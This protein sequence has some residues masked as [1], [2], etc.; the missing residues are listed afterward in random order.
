MHDH[1]AGSAG[2]LAL[3]PAAIA[4]L[5]GA[6]YVGAAWRD[7]HRRAWPMHRTA[8]WILGLAAATAAVTGPLADRAHEDLVAHMVGHLLLGMLAPLL[9][10][11]AAPVTLALRALDV[12]PA[13]RL[14]ALLRSRPL[15]AV[16]HP[17]PAAALDAG[18][19]WVV[20]GTPVLTRMHGDPLLTALVDVHVLL[21]GCLFTAAVV[22]V[23]P[24]PHRPSARY[25][26]VVLVAAM[27]AHGILAKQLYAMPPAGVPRAEAELAAQVMYHAV[28][29][30][31]LVLLGVG[32]YRA[33][34]P[35]GA[36]MPAGSGRPRIAPD[37]Q[38][39]VAEAAG[40]P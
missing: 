37:G 33:S 31:L 3:A 21:A 39:P 2:L 36:G 22:G 19:M 11:R 8:L 14:T 38:G 9:L 24:S 29:A 25:R 6:A 10:V 26:G 12:V 15:R 17:V 16:A 20:Y 18:G 1:A 28:D 30:L 40:R 7:R 13:R 32:W 5:L 27:A 35:R 34:R 4:L 23:D